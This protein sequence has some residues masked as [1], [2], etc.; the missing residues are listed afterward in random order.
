MQVHGQIELFRQ[1]KMRLKSLELASL[2]GKLKPIIVEAALANGY[3]FAGWCTRNKLIDLLEVRV[4]HLLALLCLNRCPICRS[5]SQSS[6][7]GL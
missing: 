5:L 2:V 7:I 1:F 3:N 4:E 6:F